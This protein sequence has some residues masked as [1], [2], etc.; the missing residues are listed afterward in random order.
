MFA[1]LL[2]GAVTVT[3]G[4]A[5]NWDNWSLEG[6]ACACAYGILGCVFSVQFSAESWRRQRLLDWLD[7]LTGAGAREQCCQV[8]A[9]ERLH[10]PIRSFT[11]L[12]RKSIVPE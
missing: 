2:A 3:G 1:Y 8:M 11:D 6:G 4:G 10:L 5:G 9:A 7:W 12:I